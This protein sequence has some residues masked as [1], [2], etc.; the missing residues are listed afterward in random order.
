MITLSQML[1]WSLAP[2]WPPMITLLPTRVLP[3]MPTCPANMQLLP[4]TQLWAMCT[5]S[6]NFVP[7]PTMVA[8]MVARSMVLLA[9]ISTSS[10]MNTVPIWGILRCPEDCCKNPKP[11]EPMTAPACSRQRSPMLTRSPT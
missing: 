5:L 3:A 2:T 7:E 10:P 4:M 8:E 6:S 9:P 11:S 1:I